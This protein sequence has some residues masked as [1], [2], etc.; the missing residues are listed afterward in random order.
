M[1]VSI[2]INISNTIIITISLILLISVTLAIL[3]KLIVPITSV[4]AIKNITND[5]MVGNFIRDHVKP[6]LRI[7]AGKYHSQNDQNISAVL[8]IFR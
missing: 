6:S 2:I 5:A 3:I 7:L 4:L 1:L 8:V